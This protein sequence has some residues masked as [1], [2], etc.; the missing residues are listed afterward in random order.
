MADLPE[1]ALQILT[2]RFER[3]TDKQEWVFPHPKYADRHRSRFAHEWGK[4]VKKAGLEDL[5]MHDLRH[6]L[7]TWMAN[8]GADL[9]VIQKAL[10]HSQIRMTDRYAHHSGG[11]IKDARAKAIDGM[12]GVE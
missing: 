8:S 6:T 5:R 11:V 4:F 3:R 7:A 9:A 1:P 2:R 12:M 10:G